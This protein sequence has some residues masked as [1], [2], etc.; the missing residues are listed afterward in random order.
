MTD[1]E[2]AKLSLKEQAGLFSN[3]NEYI[4][5]HDASLYNIVYCKPKTKITVLQPVK[6]L[7]E[8]NEDAFIKV[9]KILNLKYN[10]IY[11][12]GDASWRDSSYHLNCSMWS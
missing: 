4:S 7:H 11:I 8:K 9:C 6:A 12:D 5:I 3:L 1:V 10:P 2:L